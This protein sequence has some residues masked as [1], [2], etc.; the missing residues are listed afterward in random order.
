MASP[1]QTRGVD[2]KKGSGAEPQKC[3]SR[4]R[5]SDYRKKWETP[6]V[7]FLMYFERFKKQLSQAASFV[8]VGKNENGNSEVQC[9][10]P[11]LHNQMFQ[12]NEN[13][14]CVIHFITALSSR[15]WEP[16][17]RLKPENRHIL[18]IIPETRAKINGKTRDP[19]DIQNPKPDGKNWPNPQ[20]VKSQ[21]P[22][23]KPVN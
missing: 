13:Q 9:K 8:T 16:A 21:S 14:P 3:S 17:C 12:V 1:A 7:A 15:N 5:P 2:R 10:Q 4:P 22:P 19:C 20:P 6:F 18:I 11:K 23:H